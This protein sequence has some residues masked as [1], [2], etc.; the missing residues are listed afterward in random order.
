MIVRRGDVVRVDWPYSDGTGSK[1]RP[2]VVIQIDLLNTRID[3]TVLLPIS[4]TQRAVGITEVL[5]DPAT[6][7]ASG[8]RFLSAV[9]CNNF[10]TID[11]TRIMQRLGSLSAAAM[12]RIEIGLRTALGLP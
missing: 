11:Q 8:L 5:I 6:E 1:V 10:L 4:R 7:P 9:S 3:D 2:A 12:R